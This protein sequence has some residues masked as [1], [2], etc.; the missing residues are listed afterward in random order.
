MLECQDVDNIELGVEFFDILSVKL[1]LCGVLIAV[2]AKNWNSSMLFLYDIQSPV[3]IGLILRA[4][5]QFHIPVA[6]FD[7]RGIL[8]NAKSMETIS[9][10]SCGAYGRRPLELV[11]KLDGFRAAHP[12]RLIA[13]G[14]DKAAIPLPNFQFRSDDI[15]LL[16]NEYD[17]LPN[18][19][20][21]KTDATLYI[22]LPPGFLP[23]P[24]SYSPI[25]PARAAAVSKNG[26]PSLNVST[27]AAII[28]YTMYTQGVVVEENS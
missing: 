28:S 23:K 27:A 12:S 24:R 20:T 2:I 25:D 21:S 11:D 22:P 10:F 13:T 3:N 18:H 19:V 8:N 16:G 5:E 14:M 4:A 26:V 15:I 7:P 6:I 9:D 17:G 1:G